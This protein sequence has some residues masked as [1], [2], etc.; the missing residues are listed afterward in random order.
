LVELK[1]SIADE[2]MNGKFIIKKVIKME[3]HHIRVVGMLNCDCN[4]E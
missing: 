3:I 2:L 4:E 1:N